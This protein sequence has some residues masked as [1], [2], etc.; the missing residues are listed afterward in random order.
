MRMRPPTVDELE[1]EWLSGEDC[2]MADGL[3]LRS[4]MQRRCGRQS[5]ASFSVSCQWSRFH[6]WRP[7]QSRTCWHF[8]EPSSLTVSRLRRGGVRLL[9]MF[10]A[11]SGGVTFPLRFGSESRLHAGGVFGENLA[12]RLL[13]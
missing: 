2:T 8:T 3:I 13:P 7:G 5:F 11:E 10:S 9:R 4:Q 6:Y 1:S 12:A